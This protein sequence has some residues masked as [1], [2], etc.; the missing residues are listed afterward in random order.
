MLDVLLRY[1]IVVASRLI[2][3][4]VAQVFWC[5]LGLLGYSWKSMAQTSLV[6]MLVLHMLVLIVSS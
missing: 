6:G 5:F 1:K 2:V 4:L 3:C